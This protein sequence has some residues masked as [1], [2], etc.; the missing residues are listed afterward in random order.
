[1]GLEV[2]YDLVVWPCI[3]PLVAQRTSVT[4]EGY[5][6]GGL[7]MHNP[8]SSAAHIGHRRRLAW[9]WLPFDGRASMPEVGLE[10]AYDLGSFYRHFSTL[11]SI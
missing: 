8:P 5:L 10:V 4:A 3:I 9:W 1:V 11:P 7:A 6:G 2:A